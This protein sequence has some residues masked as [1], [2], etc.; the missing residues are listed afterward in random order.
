MRR[1]TVRRRGHVPLL[2]EPD[3]VDAIDEFLAGLP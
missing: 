3:C 1:V 2:D